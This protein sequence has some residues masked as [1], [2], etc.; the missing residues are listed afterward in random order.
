[1]VDNG[2][3]VK[4]DAPAPAAETA[5]TSAP[6][7][8][9]GK[10]PQKPQPPREP[11]ATEKAGKFEIM[12]GDEGFVENFE[13]EQLPPKPAGE[14][15]R[16]PATGQFKPVVEAAPV[17]EKPPE[18]QLEQETAPALDLTKPIAPL[19]TQQ[20]ARDY[21]GFSPEEARML[22]GMSNESFAYAAKLIKDNKE[23]SQLKDSTYLQ[24]PNAFVLDPQFQRM[25]EDSKFFDQEAQYWQDQL[26]LMAEGKAWKPLLRWDEQGNPVYGESREPTA[27]DQEKV[28]L[29]MSRAYDA[30][31]NA[32]GQLQ[33]MAQ[34]YA[35]RTKAG[36]AAIQAEQEKR[37]AWIADPKILDQKVAVEG[38][39]KTLRDIKSD[40]LG[41]IPPYHRG[42]VMADVAANLFTALMIYG[43]HIRTL[44][45]NKQIQQVKQ[46]EVYRAEP[47]SSAR[48]QTGGGKVVNG[49]KEFSLEGMN[50]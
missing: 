22:K 45:S 12:P 47:T 6:P 44:Q 33:Q 35:Q 39:E 20:K 10:E 15:P 3:I 28:R 50:L 19:G 32:K 25:Q 38:G 30:S 34:S 41:I 9:Q 26:A 8:S 48:P 5:P 40:F 42:N 46:E 29:A 37:F 7:P 16:D 49:V 24:H 11:T 13:T 14:K 31:H 21:T 18:G 1:M 43:N 4:V 17:A 2:G 27:L 23:L 36:D